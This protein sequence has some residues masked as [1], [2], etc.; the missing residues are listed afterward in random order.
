M[1]KWVLWVF[2]LVLLAGWLAL[3][4]V[5]AVAE[6]SAPP[7]ADP[8]DKP[9]PAATAR[10]MHDAATVTLPLV[11]LAFAI[12][13]DGFGTPRPR[14]YLA[15]VL[16]ALLLWVS[17][18]PL[19]WWP[20]GLV[21][22][23]P[24]LTLV[25][26]EGVGRWRRYA[27]AWA[28]G[29]GFG[30]MA[31]GWLRVAHPMMAVFAW[32]GVAVFL[33]LFWP[34]ALFLL[35]R[36]DKLGRPPLAL[37]LPVVWVA[38]EYFKAHFPTGYPFMKWLHLYQPSGFAW[39]F[40]GHTQHANIILLQAADL[41]GAYLLSAAVAAINGAAY[42]WLVRVRPFLWLLN[43]PRGWRLPVFRTEMMATAG[44]LL[45]LGLLG[46]YGGF[47]L[48]HPPFD[49]GP[50]VA[51][52]QDDL[53]H[54]RTQTDGPLVFSRYDK[55]SRDA[56]TTNPDLIVWPEVCYPYPEV[57]AVGA[58]AAERAA[59]RQT[60]PAAWRF[61]LALQESTAERPA[62]DPADL[63]DDLRARKD[64]A[65]FRQLLAVGPR[66]HAAANWRTHVLL[67]REA[68]DW[69]GERARKSNCARLLD[70]DGN[71]VARYDKTHLVPFGEYVPFREQVP[72]L[73][74]F[75]PN[76]NDPGCVPGE[77][78]TRFKLPTVNKSR[79]QKPWTFGA[80]I[81][82]EDT[83]PGLARRYNRWSG[84]P[85]PADFLVNQSLD[86]W[87]EG[88]EEHEQH[89]AI[90]RFRA[91]EARRSL[92]RAVHT[93]IS[94]VIDP[95]GRVVALPHDPQDDWAAQKRVPA[96]LV[97]DVPVDT[98]GSPYAVVGDW[99]PVLCWAGVLA[100]VG[101]VILHRRKRVTAPT[102]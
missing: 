44:A 55:L 75:T 99:V 25:R 90:S 37:T 98:R 17:F 67:G 2:A 79:G 64:L 59:N 1:L 101:T 14:V 9:F 5:P 83:E 22:L 43:L 49:P 70:P 21:A 6:L 10:R 42:D 27:A 41:G 24:F 18:Y 23:A 57:N 61:A 13:A 96:V 19:N 84:E 52:L 47:R 63:R 89:L 30:M 7:S 78:L 74:M 28:G 53:D 82:Y 54:A 15:A 4:L 51:L 88:S 12:A 46:I 77:T 16:S 85:D 94:A 50:K 87:F 34:P 69:D 36:L 76:P 3:A 80:L 32:P 68:V 81:C 58:T 91:V 11:L 60:I 95:D 71:P 102:T 100:G 73:A 33:S 45:V 8:A 92:V 97:A 62:F 86:S 65:N 66:D 56:A 26:A 40:L 48:L 35:R 38:L 20:L 29:L 72:A 39:Y 93:G 31:V